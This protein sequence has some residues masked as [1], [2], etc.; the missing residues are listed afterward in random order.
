MKKNKIIAVVLVA[1]MLMSLVVGCG[2]SNDTP[3]ENPT[4]IAGKLEAQFVTEIAAD[5][6]IEN[7]ANKLT[8]NECLADVSM[9][10][11]PME[12]GYLNGF[13]EEITGF[14]QAVIFCPMIRTIPFVGYI[15]ET[16][17]AD[18]LVEELKVKAMLNWNICT[19]ADEMVVRT[20]GNTVFFVMAP[21]SFDE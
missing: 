20:E 10:V 17:D 6:N 1:M 5:S 3:A 13:G 14:N 21:N 16:D 11:M 19:Q 15:F 2:K 9:I 7:V 4:T 12:P 18:A 8:T